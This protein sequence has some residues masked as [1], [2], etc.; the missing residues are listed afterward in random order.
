[1]KKLSVM[2]CLIAAILSMVSVSALAAGTEG[3]VIDLGDG[4]YMVETIVQYPM[5]RS[6][7]T[8]SGSKNGNVYYGSTLIGTAT[9]AAAFDISGSSAKA[10]EARIGGSGRNGGKYIDGN[11]YCSSNTA[12]GTAI[13]GYNGGEKSIKLT[14]SCTSDGTLY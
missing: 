2:F 9:L 8:V 14:I 4:Y 10:T 5:G 7:D 1:M 6:G 3:N 12:Y 11:A 13:F